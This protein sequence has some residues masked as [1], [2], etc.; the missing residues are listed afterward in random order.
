M[1]RVVVFGA[2]S[3]IGQAMRLCV[4]PDIEPIWCRRRADPLHYGVDLIGSPATG[5][6]D[7][8]DLFLRHFAPAAVINLAGE[9]RAD[10]VER[11]EWRSRAINVQAPAWLSWWCAQHNAHYVHLSSDQVFGGEP[12]EVLRGDVRS[13][14]PF[15][16]DS[17]RIPVNRY[18]GQKLQA[19][20]EVGAAGSSWTI[21]RP[22]FLLGV[23]PMPLVGQ[24]NFAEHWLSLPECPAEAEK[25]PVTLSMLVTEVADRW[26]S[27]CFAWEVARR[28]W[29]IACDEP[30]RHAVHVALPIRTTRHELA[31]QLRT[32][33]D[34]EPVPMECERWSLPAAVNTSMALV[35]ANDSPSTLALRLRIALFE[36]QQDY[37]RRQDLGSIQ[38]FREISIFQGQLDDQIKDMSSDHSV[39]AYR[40]LCAAVVARLKSENVTEA[41][42]LGDGIGDM[43]IALGR[44]GIHGIYH[45]IKDSLAA[46]FADFRQWL[47][48][49]SSTMYCTESMEPLIPAMPGEMQAIIAIDWLTFCSTTGAVMAMLSFLVLPPK[50]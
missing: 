37:T 47:Y 34:I 3:L 44:A 46:K 21:V 17:N 15:A 30:L 39:P 49:G 25:R 29:E 28:L 2:S 45:D 22:G 50:I 43:T 11:A 36:C 24:E 38:R 26:F 41:L 19:E 40:D 9:N 32:D 6:D 5:A 7:P 33:L 18:G 4:P 48:L 14:P 23:R 35:I 8:R 10:I 42:C 20:A 13:M 1:K 12:P 27:P 16:P 31:Q